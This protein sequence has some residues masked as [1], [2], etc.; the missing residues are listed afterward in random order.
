VL[1]RFGHLESIPPDW[2]DWRV[3]AASPGA[4]AATLER[5]HDAAMLYR[6]LATLR[7]DIPLFE[8]VDELRWKGPTPAFAALRAWLDAAAPGDAG[9]GAKSRKWR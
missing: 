5:E 1:A 9:Q 7:T 6:T 8:S 3:N 4:L 2:R